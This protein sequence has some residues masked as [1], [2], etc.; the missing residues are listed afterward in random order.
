MDDLSYVPLGSDRFRAQLIAQACRSAGLDVKLLAADDSGYGA[1]QAH[2]L[3]VLTDQL[4]KVMSVVEK[5]DTGPRRRR[6]G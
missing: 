4:E 6:R 3:L 5:S 2:R 1:V